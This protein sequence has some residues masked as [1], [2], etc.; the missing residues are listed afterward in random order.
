MNLENAKIRSELAA[1]ALPPAGRPNAG[2]SVAGKLGG[3]KVTVG[4]VIERS[5]ADADVV[6]AAEVTADAA[7][8]V[9]TLTLSSGAIAQTTG[10]PTIAGGGEDVFGQT[11]SLVT[12]YAVLLETPAGNAAGVQV[13]SS[14]DE[15]PDITALGG[16]GLTGENLSTLLTGKAAG[17]GTL[18][19][20]FGTSGDIITVTVLGKSS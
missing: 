13:A 2:L 11:I 16:A 7:S 1:F 15:L 18:A 4:N 9:A 19:F 12:L 6:Y 10:T 14:L 20:T 17:A 5:F 3:Q 8:D